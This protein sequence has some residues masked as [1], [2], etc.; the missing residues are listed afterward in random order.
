ME[1]TGQGW[2]AL[3]SPG[4]LLRDP[5]VFLGI[6]LG[7]DMVLGDPQYA[8][9]PVRVTGRVLAAGEA[10]LRKAGL[11]GRFGGF[12]LFLITAA[13]C[14]GG[15][16]A[17]AAGLRAAGEALGM[18]AL[19][20]TLDWL[21]EVYLGYSLLALGDLI[22]HGKRIAKAA[23]SGDVG[24]ARRAAG[25]L[26]GRDT[27]RMDAAACNRAAVESLAESLVDGVLSPLF[28]FALLGL[29]GLIVFKIA[30]TM[31]S[32]VGYKDE[33]YLHFG[34]FGARLDDVMNYLPARLC[35]LLITAWSAIA[36]G[37]SAR[38]AWAT[39]LGQHALLPGPNKGWSETAA[40]GALDIRLAGPIYKHGMLVNELWIGPENAPEG[41]STRDVDRMIRLAY[42]TTALF[43][44]LAWLLLRSGWMAWRG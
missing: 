37:Y 3:I 6:C 43:M 16:W 15:A 23:A 35:L 21:W 10:F 38:K 7:L 25:M 28:W 42:G 5:L 12:L 26:V 18:P 31:D 44:A 9:H 34:W 2:P 39:S 27:D 32:M 24:A 36:P 11:D 22:V 33:R 8:W 1:I 13:V 19:G 41:G 14:G 20:W 29:P 30:S 17:A 4:G 40:A